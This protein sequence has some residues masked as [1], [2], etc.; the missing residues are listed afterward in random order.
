MKKLLGLVVLALALVCVLTAAAFAKRHTHRR[1][2]GELRV[3]N[4]TCTCVPPGELNTPPCGGECLLG[5]G[6]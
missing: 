4:G 5:G 6:P 3:V 2:D 1:I